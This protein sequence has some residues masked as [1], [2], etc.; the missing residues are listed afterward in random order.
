MVSGDGFSRKFSSS[1]SSFNAVS[2]SLSLFP[3]SP[4]SSSR[5][6][7]SSSF[8]YYFSCSWWPCTL[9]LS[10]IIV[11][12]FFVFSATYVINIIFLVVICLFILLPCPSLFFLSL[13]LVNIFFPGK[14]I[15]S[16]CFRKHIN[17]PPIATTHIFSCYNIPLSSSSSF[18]IASFP[19]PH[20][21]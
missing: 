15:K 20:R 7:I 9:A 8:P 12:L 17:L 3:S 16:I 18:P 1:A 19:S 14:L 21:P 5:C 10:L 11:L 13:K 4:L 2:S 6:S